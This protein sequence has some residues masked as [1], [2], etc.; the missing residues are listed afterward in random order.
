MNDRKTLSKKSD[1]IIILI[2]L[3]IAVGLFLFFKFYGNKNNNQVLRCEII[4]DGKVIYEPDLSV[5]GTFSLPEFHDVL[6]EIKSSSIAF[7]HSN[8]PDQV[9]VRTGFI[10]HSAQTAVCLPNKLI[11]KIY[12]NNN[13]IDDIDVIA[14]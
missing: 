8:C 11:I 2:I 14:G 4:C 3:F 12:K 10:S 7:I 5:D 13:L 1:F 9:C 6:F